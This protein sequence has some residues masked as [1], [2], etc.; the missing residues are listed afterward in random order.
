MTSRAVAGVSIRQQAHAG[1]G[2]LNGLQSEEV[3]GLSWQE[4]W[5]ACLGCQHL[6]LH[7]MEKQSCQGYCLHCQV[8]SHTCAG[9]TMLKHGTSKAGQGAAHNPHLCE[10]AK[11]LIHC[12][13]GR[14]WSVKR[15]TRKAGPSPAKGVYSAQESKAVDVLPDGRPPVQVRLPKAQRHKCGKLHQL[16]YAVNDVEQLHY[17]QHTEKSPCWCIAHS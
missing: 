11:Q 3:Q 6:G 16:G 7:S 13:K 1:R 17:L 12:L 14:S 5:P 4:M 15:S 8:R 9:H 10:T 2:T